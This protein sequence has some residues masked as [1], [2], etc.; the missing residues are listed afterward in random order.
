MEF[1][2]QQFG[3]I[4]HSLPAAFFLFFFRE[5]FRKY[6]LDFFNANAQKEALPILYYI[7]SFSLITLSFFGISWGGLLGNFRKDT[8]FTFLIS[9]IWFLVYILLLLFLLFLKQSP[10]GSIFYLIIQ[11]S[12]KY[13]WILFILNFLPIPP[14]DGAFFYMQSFE[15]FTTGRFISFSIKIIFI[16]LLLFFSTQMIHQNFLF[17]KD[18]L[19]LLG[20]NS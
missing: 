10:E 3:V 15:T 2:I 8:I 19:I 20:V 1:N 6:V 12:I 4:I 18:L 13:S 9:Q 7:D 11:D 5:L 14:F 16:V 17:T